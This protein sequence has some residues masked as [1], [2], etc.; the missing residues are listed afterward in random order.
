M[1]H[2]PADPDAGAAPRLLA[3]GDAALTVEFGST[4]AAALNDRVLALDAAV[5]AAAR[6]GVVETVPTYRSLT[7]TFDPLATDVEALGAFLLATAARTGTAAA[8]PRRWLV[9]VVYGG[10]FGVDLDDLAARHKLTPAEVVARHAAP[11]YRVFVIGFMPG[12]SYLGG[13]DAGLETPRRPQ[14]RPKVPAQSIMIGGAQTAISS[15]ECPS[16][17][18]LIGRTPVRPF[19]EGREPVF[20]TQPGDEIVFR[21]VAASE[22]EALDRRAAAGEPVAEAMA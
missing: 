8:K 5:R 10:A 9:P 3:C 20:L 13:L 22:W 6:P 14:P 16:G 4:V 2:R 21:P 17:W 18:H 1:S 7:V 15:V 12:F 19:M 11:V